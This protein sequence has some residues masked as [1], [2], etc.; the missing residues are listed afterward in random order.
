VHLDGLKS[1]LYAPSEG[2]GGATAADA[3]YF[4]PNSRHTVRV[5]GEAEGL[6]SAATPL[7]GPVERL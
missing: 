6:G 4:S 3:A 1:L 7:R 2:G 5:D